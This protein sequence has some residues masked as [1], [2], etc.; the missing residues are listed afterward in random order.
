VDESALTGE[1]LPVDK[2]AIR[3]PIPICAGRTPKYGLLFYAGQPRKGDGDRASTGMDTEIGRI[4][5]MARQ[6]KEPRTPLQNMMD[7]LSKFL[8]WFALGF[9]V[10]VP[11]SGFLRAPTAQTDAAHRSIPGSPPSPKRC[12]SSSP[13]CCRWRFPAVEKTRYCQAV[14]CRRVPGVV[15]VI[16]T[17]K[18]G[19]LT[20]NCMEVARFEPEGSKNRLLEIGVFSNDAVQNGTE[21]AGDPVDAALLRAARKPGWTLKPSALY[22]RSLMNLP[23]T[24]RA[25]ACDC[26]PERRAAVAAVKGAQKSSWRNARSR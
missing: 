10:L 1:S 6:V 11:W 2:N 17:D 3:L 9:S 21:F 15:T 26:Y 4:A 20:E 18:T 16:A 13:W 8:V 22:I 12:R 5:G 24:T 19:T 25:S 23:L 14:E 7:E